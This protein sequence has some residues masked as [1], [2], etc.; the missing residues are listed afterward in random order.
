MQHQRRFKNLRKEE[1]SKSI[2]WSQ[3]TMEGTIYFIF[4]VGLEMKSSNETKE[5][6]EKLQIV[7]SIPSLFSSFTLLY[8]LHFSPYTI[9]IFTTHHPLKMGKHIKQTHLAV[10]YFLGQPFRFNIIY[11][12]LSLQH[13]LPIWLAESIYGRQITHLSSF[14]LM[15]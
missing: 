7:L 5:D 14:S 13:H 15:K 6:G 3:L 9:Y 11:L 1:S 2:Q 12:P 10:K 8:N 4:G